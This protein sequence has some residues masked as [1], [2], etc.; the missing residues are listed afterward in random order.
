MLFI[1]FILLIIFLL[2]EGTVTYLPLTLILLLCLVIVNRSVFIFI[3]AFFAGLLLDIFRLQ[4]LGMT[5]LFYLVFLFLIL[6][7]RRKYEIRSVPFV[8]IA[9]FFG[10]VIYLFLFKYNN[11]LILSILSSLFALLF[12]SI[13]RIQSKNPNQN[14]EFRI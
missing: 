8:F 14:L 4:P 13:L 9:S 5:S 3:L 10:S 11:I 2:L 7:Y 1:S 12:F 6:L